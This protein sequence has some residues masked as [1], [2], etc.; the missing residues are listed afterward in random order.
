MSKI[1]NYN[2]FLDEIIKEVEDELE[3]STTTGN[4]DGYQTPYA[5]GDES[6]KNQTRK[7]Q[8][9]TQAGYSV[10]DDDVKNINETTINKQRATAELKQKLRGKRSDG[11]GKYTATVYGLDNT[12]KRVELKSLS[13]INK[14]SKFEL[15]ESI[16][17]GTIQAE[18]V[19]IIAEFLY[20]NDFTKW[21]AV[22]TYLGI[23]IVPLFA[24][25]LGNEWS[26][27]KKRFKDWKDAK[28]LDRNKLK[29]LVKDLE[30]KIESLPRGK[31]IF[32]K[33]IV[34]KINNKVDVSSDDDSNIK[35]TLMYL[36]RDLVDYAKRYNI[37]DESINEASDDKKEKALKYLN[38]IKIDGETNSVE[39]IVKFSKHPNGYNV[40]YKLK[41]GMYDDRDSGLVSDFISRSSIGESKEPVK[42]T[43]RWLELKNDDT[44]HGHKK[45]AV[46]LKELKYQLAEVEKFLGWYNKLK[47]INE[48]DSDNYWKRTNN[49][50]YKIKERLVN[51]V[52]KLQEIEK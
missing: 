16:N 28:F 8:V 10:V 13:D 41:K 25:F 27:I 29:S 34:N 47:N 32:I 15:S 36:Q 37:M 23:Y 26:D 42:R 21:Q 3:E 24:L 46:G 43:N 19:K 6:E 50:I 11:M 39:K 14:Y 52:K 40:T 22:L 9:A 4:I 49:N 20:G 44:M 5:F 35:K 33:G 12:G 45:L 18:G 30:Q 2:K 17:E 48:L 7:K 1:S 38:S 31:K 51:I